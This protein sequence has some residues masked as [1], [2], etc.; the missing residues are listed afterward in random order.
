MGSMKNHA[1][2]K[3]DKIKILY[4]GVFSLL[5]AGSFFLLSTSIRNIFHGTDLLWMIP[6]LSHISQHN[7]FWETVKILFFNPAPTNYGEPSMNLYLF[8]TYH[9]IGFKAQYFIFISA[10]LHLFCVFF[11]YRFLQRIGFTFKM[12]FL[13]ALI[14]ATSFFHSFYFLWP[15]SMQHL[16]TMFFVLLTLNLFLETNYRLDHGLPWKIIFWQALFVNLLASFCPITIFVLP[17]AIFVYI[18]CCSENHASRIKKYDLWLPLFMTYFG[19]RLIR[20]LFW[21]YP[22]CYQSWYF[23]IFKKILSRIPFIGKLTVNAGPELNPFIVFSLFFIGGILCLLLLRFLLRISLRPPFLAFLKK[24]VSIGVILYLIIFLIT[25]NFRNIVVPMGVGIPLPDFISPYNFIRPLAGVFVSF[26][27][28]IRSALSINAAA[29]YCYIP[30]NSNILWT[31]LF[32][33]LVVIFLRKVCFKYKPLIFF[34]CIYIFGLPLLTM[35]SLWEMNNSIPSRY[36]VYVTPLFA[37]IFSTSFIIIYDFFIN[38]VKISVFKK[39]LILLVFFL[40]LCFLNI[41]AIN[42]ILLKDK[43]VNEFLSYDYIKGASLIKQDLAAAKDGIRLKDVCVEGVLPIPFHQNGWDF[44]PANPLDLATFKYTLA[45]VLN[46][47]D[48]SNVC[49]DSSIDAKKNKITYIFDKNGVVDQKGQTIDPFLRLFYK[50]KEELKLENY[51]Q[52]RKLLEAAAQI[53]PFFFQFIFPNG[54]LEDI[55]WMANGRS[56]RALIDDTAN[57]YRGGSSSR[58]DKIEYI[59]NMLD[60]EIKDYIECFFYLSYLYYIEKKL[61]DSY[62]WYSRIRFIDDRND[63]VVSFLNQQPLIKSDL[64]MQKYIKEIK[65]NPSYKRKGGRKFYSMDIF[66]KLFFNDGSEE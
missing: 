16:A 33:L 41:F 20:D 6:T 24:L 58:I 10:I 40:I 8:L 14:Y 17:V 13:A 52:A 4:L 60:S 50:A 34:A 12:A 1:L 46:E 36:L 42:L 9:F 39:E 15:M 29:P 54:H 22:E 48:A 2:Q 47:R 18:I 35:K 7:S 11:F 56:A 23:D 30:M 64:E 44:S 66:F 45:Q 32:M 59:A 53:R 51:Q 61:P 21:G 38:K 43:F 57:Y 3:T 31:V 28:P 26:V 65:S 49:V 5:G 62:Y 55:L 25:L 37:V 63:E 19:Y 27:N